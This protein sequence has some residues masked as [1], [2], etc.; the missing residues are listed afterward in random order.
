VR[1]HGRATS[2]SWLPAHVGVE[3]HVCPPPYQVG[4]TAGL[5]GNLPAPPLGSIVYAT[6]RSVLAVLE[7]LVVAIKQW[8]WVAPCAALPP[9]E[10]AAEKY[11]ALDGSLRERLAVVHLRPGKAA[12]PTDAARAVAMRHAPTAD[13]LAGWICTRLGAQDLSAPLVE[14]VAYALGEQAS[15]PHSTSWYSRAFSSHSRFAAKDWRAAAT[16][17][18]A[19]HLLVR[20]RLRFGSVADGDSAPALLLRTTSRYSTKYLG[21]TCGSAI[22]RVGWEWVLEAILRHR[23]SPEFCVKAEDAPGH[24]VHAA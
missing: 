8:P 7:Q 24:C 4:H 16:L 13:S 20:E 22:Q 10:Y 5:A 19:H 6:G 1:E 14:Q 11:A 12:N 2:D 17:V 23:S 15:L 18:R 9:T 3:L 21:A